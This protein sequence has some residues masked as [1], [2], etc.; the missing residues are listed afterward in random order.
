[1]A[2]Q[3]SAY[4]FGPDHIHRMTGRDAESATVHVYSPPLWRMGQYT[5][6][7]NGVL[8]RLSVS[9]AD[10]LRPLEPA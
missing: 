10:E 2:E 4:S 8:R 9:Y 1:V 6:S 7:Q 5:I 3:G